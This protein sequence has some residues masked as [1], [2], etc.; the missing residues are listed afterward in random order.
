MRRP[1]VF[2]S[3]THKPCRCSAVT[4]RPYRAVAARSRPCPVWKNPSGVPDFCRCERAGDDRGGVHLPVQ[5]PDDLHGRRADARHA[6]IVAPVDHS[7]DVVRHRRVRGEPARRTHRLRPP[8][9]R[10]CTG[11]L[12]VAETE[13]RE[14]GAGTRRVASPVQILMPTTPEPDS[15]PSRER[16]VFETEALLIKP[17]IGRLTS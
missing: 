16:P 12:L 7:C 6:T 11:D 4:R 2:P 3:E 10:H 8:N 15:Y 14:N 17:S 9:R 5:G 13:R 1:S